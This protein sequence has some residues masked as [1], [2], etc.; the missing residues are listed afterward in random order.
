MS[1]DWAEL[2]RFGLAQKSCQDKNI[3]LAHQFQQICDQIFSTFFLRWN[4]LTSAG[5]LL[6]MSSSRG[7]ADKNQRLPLNDHWPTLSPDMMNF[8]MFLVFASI[9]LLKA[10]AI[11]IVWRCYKF[12]STRQ[13]NI[14]SSLPFVAPEIEVGAVSLLKQISYFTS[15]F[16]FFGI[17]RES[18]SFVISFLSILTRFLSLP[19]FASIFLTRSLSLPHFS[20]FF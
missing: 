1:T 13:I 20:S 6:Y 18:L 9:V 17:L 7:S 11:G 12:L 19:H 16:L 5:Y 14:R 10:Y 15:F 3:I 2:V 8:L 4:S